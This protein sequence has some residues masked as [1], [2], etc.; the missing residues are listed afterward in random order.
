MVQKLKYFIMSDYLE[1]FAFCSVM[2]SP[3]ELST[4]EKLHQ[5]NN[6]QYTWYDTK[7]IPYNVI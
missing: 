5:L 7:T 6:R 4:T 2:Y 3:D 1:M